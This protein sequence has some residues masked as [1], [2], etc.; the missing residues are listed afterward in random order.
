M[1]NSEIVSAL[2]DS[3]SKETNEFCVEG[4][5]VRAKPVSALLIQEVVGRIK[6]PKPPLVANPDKDGA[7]EPNP[8][9][10]AYVEALVEANTRRADATTNTLVMFGLELVDG[11]P[12]DDAWLT[13]LRKL[14]KMGLIDLSE[15]DLDDP[16][17]RD[18][19]F[20]K[21]IAGTNATIMEVSKASGVSQEDVNAAIESFPGDA[22]Q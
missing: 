11:L 2:K 21:Y 1:K 16:F 9:D 17:E 10:P 7:L 8:F 18:F 15:I 13:K 19:I 6:D 4:V 20:K 12:K 14:D 22:T 3:E 5:L